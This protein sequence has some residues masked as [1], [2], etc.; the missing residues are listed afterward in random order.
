MIFIDSNIFIFA[1]IKEYPEYETAKEKIEK[2]IGTDTLAV[3]S[4]IVSEVQYKL[5]RLLGSKE[6]LKRTLNI[7]SSEYVKYIPIEK[8][9]IMEAVNLSY[10]KNIRINDAI[11]AR[12][13]MDSNAD[14]LTDNVK[15]FKKIPRLNLIP[16]KD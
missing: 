15:D 11:I 2:L 12:H 14:L 6:S 7:L 13:A 1:N 9:T 4:I 16:L 3:N 8:D 10:S 5:Y